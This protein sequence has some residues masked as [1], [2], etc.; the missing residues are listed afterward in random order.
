MKLAFNKCVFAEWCSFRSGFHRAAIPI[1][2]AGIGGPGAPHR[3]EFTRRSDSGTSIS[4]WVVV[5]CV[6]SCL[7]SVLATTSEC[8]D[9][10]A[11]AGRSSARGDFYRTVEHHTAS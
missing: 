8:C 1:H 6:G 9:A 3:F 2:L 11:G 10:V 7:A 4:F 5:C